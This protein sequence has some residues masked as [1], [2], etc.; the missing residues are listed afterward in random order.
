MYDIFI[1]YR[2]DGGTCI[3]N[4]LA[5]ILSR[6]GYKV[7]F[8]KSSLRNGKF[9]EKLLE[10]I[11][12]CKDFIVI[13]NKGAFDRTLEGAKE[14]WMPKELAHAKKLKKNIIPVKLPEFEFPTLDKLPDNVK[15]EYTAIDYSVEYF[16]DFYNKLKDRLKS[17]AS[18][19]RH[20]WKILACTGIAVI[21]LLALYILYIIIFPL[22]T[23]KPVLLIG[24]GSVKG[25]L[26]E[27]RD[28]STINK[29]RYIP[30]P[31][32]TVW[33]I[34]TE[35]IELKSYNSQNREYYM[36]F[37]SAQRI[38]PNDKITKLFTSK[39]GYIME[40]YI[41]DNYLQMLASDDFAEEL[42]N[43]DTI[44]I[45]YLASILNNP[46]KFLK[47]PNSFLEDSSKAITIYTTTPNTSGTYKRYQEVLNDYGFYLDSIHSYDRIKQSTYYISNNRGEYNKPYI[48]LE[49]STYKSNADKKKAIIV[50]KDN[51]MITNP[52]FIYFIVYKSE[53]KYI[54]PDETRRFLNDIGYNLPQNSSPSLS[55]E[56]NDSLIQTYDT[57]ENKAMNRKI[58]IN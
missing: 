8:D 15:I 38:M 42:R 56:C 22:K 16:K 51:K 33:P 24:G 17:K 50:K 44:S 6:D 14:D 21:C 23:E 52:L 43:K 37:L 39:I 4:H 18:L 5:D 20:L 57:I 7:F 9:D 53:D 34:I 28:S 36:I 10:H 49:A 2:H 30:A 46:V 3:A 31:S 12:S 47:E 41:G 35:E 45:E 55:P 1:S 48:I 11:E 40:I 32:S 29:Y 25:K 26:I 19:K 54:I 27:R 13:L 58:L